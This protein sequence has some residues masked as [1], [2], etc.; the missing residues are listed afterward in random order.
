MPEGILS[1]SGRIIIPVTEGLQ[2]LGERITIAMK[3][4]MGGG[5]LN[6]VTGG[7]NCSYAREHLQLREGALAATGGNKCNLRLNDMQKRVK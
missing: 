4:G 3:V 1:L 5:P 6:N 7:Q 2:S